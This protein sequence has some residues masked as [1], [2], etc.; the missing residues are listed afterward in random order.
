MKDLKQE[1]KTISAK[2]NIMDLNKGDRVTHEQ[3][4]KQ[5]RYQ[6]LQAEVNNLIWTEQITETMIITANLNLLNWDSGTLWSKARVLLL[7][8]G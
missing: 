2:V 5:A 1:T 4:F 3:V 7:S 8:Y 6:E